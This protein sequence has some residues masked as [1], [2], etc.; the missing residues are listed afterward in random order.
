M[1]TTNSHASQVSDVTHLRIIINVY[2]TIDW[3]DNT[4]AEV[5][6]AMNENYI[7]VC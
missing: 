2:H 6:C 4:L 5:G 1:Y 7:R 3:C